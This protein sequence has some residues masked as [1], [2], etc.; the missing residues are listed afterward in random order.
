M[1]LESELQRAVELL[2]QADG[3]VVAA[4]AGMGVNSGLP[5]FRGEEGFWQAYPALG[6]QGIR[7]QSIATP[8]AFRTLP[9]VAWGF[10][11]HRLRL[12]RET[13]P[14]DGFQWLRQWGARCLQGLTVFTSNVDGQFQK[15]GFDPAHVHECHGSIHRLQCLDA[16]SARTWPADGFEPVVDEASGELV[17][18]ELPTCPDCGALARPNILMFNDTGWIGGP[19]R[20]QAI[21]QEKWLREVSRPV[22]VEL[23]AG[24][25]IPS[26]RF[27][28]H[29]IIHRHGGR[30]IRINP[31]EATVPTPMD[32]GLRMGALAALRGIDG[33]SV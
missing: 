5:D 12:Y 33:R 29:E 3:L 15:A 32:V 30:L 22:V 26:V 20:M 14:H 2:A 8:V 11:G 28:S 21:R 25:A 4:G 10:Y 13:V 16:C 31:T 27:F 23:G 19:T 18:D 17:N 6:R 9:R 24:V 7:F 1:D